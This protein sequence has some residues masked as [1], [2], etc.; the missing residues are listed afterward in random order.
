MIMA[1]RAEAKTLGATRYFTGAPCCNG[2]IDA[3]CTSNWACAQ[4]NR[5][6][7]SAWRKASPDKWRAQKRRWRRRNAAN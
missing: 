4:C 2:H 6:N 7:K 1:T 5:D 3:R